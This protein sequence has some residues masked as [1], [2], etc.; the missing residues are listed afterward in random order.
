MK[1][2]LD[3]PFED[4]GIFDLPLRRILGTLRAPNLSH[5]ALAVADDDVVRQEATAQIGDRLTGSYRFEEFDYADTP[6]P[7]LLRFYRQLSGDDGDPVCLIAHG[8]DVLKARGGEAYEEALHFLNM[9]REDLTLAHGA[10]VLWLTADTWKDV[11]EQAPDFADW[12]SVSVTFELPADRRLERT[13]LGRLSI[14]DA[15]DVRR[16]VRRFREMLAR[17]NLGVALETEFREQLDI[18]ERRLGRIEDVRRDYRMHLVDEL[19]EH[20][21]GGFAPQVGGRVLSLPLSKV[22]LPLRAVEGRPALAEYA[23]EDLHWQQQRA[24]DSSE[25]DWRTRREEME[26]RHARL[27]HRQAVQRSFTLEELLKERRAVLLGDPG[28]GKTTVTRYVAWALAAGDYREVGEAIRGRLPVLVRLASYGKALEAD[29]ELTLL[30]YVGSQLMPRVAF[31]PMLRAAVEAGECLMILD[32]LDEVTDPDLRGDVALRIQALVNRN[33]GNRFLVT[34][35]IVGYDHTPLTREYQHATL[36]ELDDDDRKRFVG[37]W[38]AAIRS[39]I[40]D[41]DL[42]MQEAELLETLETRPQIARM[43]ANPLLL[44]IM[45]L[46]HWRGV[47]LPS[48]RVQVYQTATDTLIEYRTTE[49]AKLDAE[50]VKQLLA[51][52]AYYILSSN[53]GG[54]IARHDLLPRLREGIIA[55]RGCDEEEA[56]S[57]CRE[58]VALLSEQSG[59]FLERGLD[60]ER[61][62]VYGFLHQTFAEYLAALHLSN[63]FLDGSFELGKYIHRS[64]WKE[65]LL[66]LAGHLSLFSQIHVT[67]LLRAIL[68]H[69]CPYED[70]L[71]RNVLLAAECLADD[72]QVAPKVRDEV[73]KKLAEML[74]DEA[75][76][77]RKA[78][79]E[80]YRPVGRS[81][82]REPAVAAVRELMSSWKKLDQ[83]SEKDCDSAL[84]LLSA[85]VHLEERDDTA[86]LLEVAENWP[87]PDLLRLQVEG[88]PEK[89][90]SL[91]LGKFRKMKRYILA[92]PDLENSFLFSFSAHDLQNLFGSDRF[93]DFLERL[94]IKT[95]QSLYEKPLCW[96]RALSSEDSSMDHFLNLAKQQE[97]PFVS[98]LAAERLLQ[99]EYRSVGLEA[100]KNMVNMGFMGAAEALLSLEGEGFI[101][102]D[103]VRDVA[104]QPSG[105]NVPFA[106]RVLLKARRFDVALPATFLHLSH[107][108]SPGYSRQLIV[109]E[110]Q[111]ESHPRLAYLVARWLALWPGYDHRLEAC[112][113]LADSG[114]IEEAIPLLRI[115]A[116][117]CHGEASRKACQRLLTLKEVEPVIP[118]LRHFLESS[119]LDLRYE[120]ALSLALVPHSA[121]PR[122]D[123]SRSEI[124]ASILEER[125]RLFHQANVEL[126]EGGLALLRRCATADSQLV[127]TLGRL[128]LTKLCGHDFS[129]KD[130]EKLPKDRIPAFVDRNL[131]FF[132]LI[133][134]R[135]QRARERLA[136]SAK[137]FW[138]TPTASMWFHRI[139][140]LV[141]NADGPGNLETLWLSVPDIFLSDPGP[142]FLKKKNLSQ[143]LDLLGDEDGQ[144]RSAACASLGRQK[145]AP[146]MPLVA[147]LND[148]GG[149]VRAEAASAL[150][151]LGAADAAEYL[152]TALGDPVAQVRGSAALALARLGQREAVNRM[153]I[154]AADVLINFMEDCAG[155]DRIVSALARL[156]ARRALPMLVACAI[157]DRLYLGALLP[158]EPRS[159]L[160]VVDRFKFPLMVPGWPHWLRGHALWRL[161]GPEAAESAFAE[162]VDKQ[163]TIEHLLTLALLRLEQHDLADAHACVKHAF[164]ECRENE[165]ERALCFLTRAVITTGSSGLD[166]AL[167]DV[168]EAVCLDPYITDLQDL[169]FDHLWRPSA[170]EIVKELIPY[171]ETEP[172]SSE[173][174]E[175]QYEAVS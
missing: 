85:F 86:C 87:S 62:P 156:N 27:R 170:L 168:R 116:Y 81:R 41:R 144:V 157:P 98:M 162:A 92:G 77:P 95:R 40:H 29:R 34:S 35:R 56:E 4:G 70:I 73:L 65:P 120:A 64:A 90:E 12:E 32:G 106:A 54:V 134:G 74:L 53:V 127:A 61:R 55:Q 76:K 102:W 10:V 104:F 136:R 147:L 82:H 129:R 18:A 173:M 21:L 175:E 125:H 51:P 121:K 57:I 105:D 142:D 131:I 33:A 79:T 97:Q 101:D 150:G 133:E 110:M 139:T 91:L 163:P 153:I 69:P 167:A 66:L 94:T 13:A 6:M 117:E 59:L 112:E 165:Q 160:D 58:L 16:Q 118:V 96:L 23:E 99:T 126:Y 135:R 140:K 149:Q 68:D 46:M 154:A 26:K 123:L 71:R 166:R 84:A 7:S 42:A 111:L 115:V 159:T 124:K 38:Y 75:T 20:M 109:D 11:L 122:T 100:L 24:D 164:G 172:L 50:E 119:D 113:F 114:R 143:L 148:S 72:I 49:R 169:E 63:L 3:K 25:L 137:S 130:L 161:E 36:Q 67:R 39:E 28:S 152:K 43:G 93:N 78:A 146:T 48:R 47:K 14:H 128:S 17:P 2:V 141:C 138:T 52:V 5:L 15:E 45:V 8:L 19:R 30:D 1:T 174:A 89:A 103:V 151:R 107:A 158:L 31:G 145:K 83:L 9:H 22:F 60:A 108:S 37:L 80:L 44:T 171:V 88:W 155:V 132:D